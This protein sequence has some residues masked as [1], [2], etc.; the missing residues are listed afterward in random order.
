[1]NQPLLN[2]LHPD[3]VDVVIQRVEEAEVD[4]MWSYMGKKREP[5]WLW[6]AMDHHT[7]KVLA[8]VFGRRHDHVFLQRKG[9]LEPFG[10]TRYDTDCWGAYPRHRDPAA[11]HPGKGNMQQIE[12]QQL[13]LRTRLKRLTRQTIRFSRSI[14]MHDIVVGLFGNRYEFGLPV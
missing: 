2:A 12:P 5:H 10:I 3:E 7:G 14:Q 11:H 4:E 6:H 1:V 9:L 13:T 8:S